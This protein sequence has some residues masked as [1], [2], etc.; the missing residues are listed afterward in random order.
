MAKPVPAVPSE[1]NGAGDGAGGTSPVS[2][3]GAG[4]DAGQEPITPAVGDGGPALEPTTPAA[5]DA[6]GTDAPAE[7][8][9]AP[10]GA[11]GGV[12]APDAT[13]GGANSPAAA[14][15]AE[16]VD[17]ILLSDVEHDNVRLKAGCRVTLPAAAA[18][19]LLGCG[20]AELAA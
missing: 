11:A 5:S 10:Q 20:A 2:T 16:D 9:A 17:L 8:P 6:A 14:A 13:G 7:S 15:P 12:V 4:G 1:F 18:R 3:T 19:P